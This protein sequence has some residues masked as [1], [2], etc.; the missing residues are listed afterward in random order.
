[1]SDQAANHG[2]V[3]SWMNPT[4]IARRHLGATPQRVC[5]VINLLGLRQVD[6]FLNDKPIVELFHLQRDIQRAHHKH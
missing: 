2:V 1:M 6:G 5:Q 3:A 4:E